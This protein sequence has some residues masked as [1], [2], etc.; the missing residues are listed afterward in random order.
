MCQ[1]SIERVLDF[2][3]IPHK[4]NKVKPFSELCS[5]R[6]SDKLDLNRTRLLNFQ[7]PTKAHFEHLQ[8]ESLQDFDR[9][10]IV[11]VNLAVTQWRW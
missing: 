10:Q 2:K 3:E 8:I 5:V 6:L 1:H 11:A 4:E 9:N 7:F